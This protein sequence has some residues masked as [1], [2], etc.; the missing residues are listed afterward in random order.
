MWV[1][2]VMIMCITSRYDNVYNYIAVMMMSITSYHDD[3]YIH[4][5][6]LIAHAWLSWYVFNYASYELIVEY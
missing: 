1:V 4:T 3:V 5:C 2:V 6:V